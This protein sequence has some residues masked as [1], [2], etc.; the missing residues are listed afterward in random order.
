MVKTLK[1]SHNNINQSNYYSEN[2][3]NNYN[4]IEYSNEDNSSNDEILPN[5]SLNSFINWSVD[6]NISYKSYDDSLYFFSQKEKNPDESVKINP[7]EPKNTPKQDDTNIIPLNN[8]TNGV[9]P[10]KNTTI[11][12]NPPSTGKK[13]IFKIKKK[14]QRK[15]DADNILSKIKRNYI[16]RYLHKIIN[17]IL[18]KNGSKHYFEKFPQN[19][20]SDVNKKNNKNLSDMRLFQICEDKKLITNKMVQIIQEIKELE[21]LMD[22]KYSE[23]FKEYIDS[24]EYESSI[25]RLKIKNMGKDYI[26]KYEKYAENFIEHFSV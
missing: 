15:K 24:K 1:L 5:F 18:K 7:V 23:L 17:G 11:I 8:T 12:T 16:N 4:E 6:D 14:R 2:S 21:E 10:N 22:K 26:K 13:P 3:F 19:F 9:K 20:V 25:E